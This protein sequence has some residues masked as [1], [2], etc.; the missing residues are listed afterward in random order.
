MRPA[1]PSVR[2]KTGF[3]HSKISPADGGLVA[4]GWDS[5]AELSAERGGDGAVEAGVAQRPRIA[6]VG[7]VE[8]ADFAMDGQAIS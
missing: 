4:I 8:A 6:A 7:R 1:S 5:P 3:F 2:E